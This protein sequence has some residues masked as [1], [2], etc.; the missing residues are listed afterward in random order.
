MVPLDPIQW[1]SV[2]IEARIRR[3]YRRKGGVFEHVQ[4]A[5]HE[6]RVHHVDVGAVAECFL[7]AV[8]EVAKRV[9]RALGADPQ[10]WLYSGDHDGHVNTLVLDPA[11]DR[12]LGVILRLRVGLERVLQ[13]VPA[14]SRKPWP[15]QEPFW[16][17]SA[18][19]NEARAAVKVQGLDVA[20]GLRFSAP[21]K[22]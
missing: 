19:E 20:A 18:F 16:R 4:K 2:V 6:S 11:K 10:R 14:D 9:P 12:V 1:L 3:P 21:D 8:S 22:P 5:E 15:R 7:H 17:E 13:I